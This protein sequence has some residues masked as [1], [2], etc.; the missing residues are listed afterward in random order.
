M[1]QTTHYYRVGLFVLIGFALLC[2]AIVLF[3]KNIMFGD[4]GGLFETFFD[5]SVQGLEIGSPVKIRGVKFAQVE[6]IELAGTVYDTTNTYIRVVMRGFPNRIQR[7]SATAGHDADNLESFERAIASGLRLRQ[8]SAG[9]TGGAYIEGDFVPH[10]RDLPLDFKPEYAYCPSQASMKSKVSTTAEE[11][12]ERLSKTPFDNLAKNLDKM[13]VSLDGVIQEL[14]P[15]LNRTETT[16]SN[17]AASV[18]SI[19]AEIHDLLIDDLKPMLANLN[20]ASSNLPATMRSLEQTLQQA[21]GFAAEARVWGDDL[22]SSIQSLSISSRI[23]MENLNTHPASSLLGGPPPAL[24][25]L[26]PEGEA[27]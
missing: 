18:E 11:I 26:Q 4:K 2:A 17:L 21:K 8:A 5:E 3:G 6:R 16:V 24:D 15:S 25:I 14:G 13:I 1:K 20:Q 12:M 19:A 27:E 22:R 10:A 23:F 9:I 7:P